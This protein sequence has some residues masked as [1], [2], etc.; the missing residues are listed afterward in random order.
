MGIKEEVKMMIEDCLHSINIVDD[1]DRQYVSQIS[2]VFN[3]GD[4]VLSPRQI[5]NLKEIWNRVK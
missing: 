2:R 5:E 3:D 1:F 4:K